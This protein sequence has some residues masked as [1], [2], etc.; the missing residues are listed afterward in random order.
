MTE[1]ARARPHFDQLSNRQIQ[2]QVPW[3]WRTAA[4]PSAKP[5]VQEQAP[6]SSGRSANLAQPISWRALRIEAT[7][8][9][10]GEASRTM[11]YPEP[12]ERRICIPSQGARKG[13]EETGPKQKLGADSE[14]SGY[15]GVIEWNRYGSMRGYRR[16]SRSKN[17]EGDGGA[18]AHGYVCRVWGCIV[19]KGIQLNT[20]SSLTCLG[21]RRTPRWWV[22]L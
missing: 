13:G 16:G 15:A 10:L 2:A 7:A 21:R 6:P 18:G 8:E 5:C 4:M 11:G 12:C 19:R 9:G 3:W 22:V 20:I 17:G 14:G 1:Y